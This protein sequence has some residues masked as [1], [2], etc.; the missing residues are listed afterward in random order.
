MTV[1]IIQSQVFVI[2]WVEPQH[3]PVHNSRL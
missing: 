1:D 3:N 2:T